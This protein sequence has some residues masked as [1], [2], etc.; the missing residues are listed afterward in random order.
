M[1]RLVGAPLLGIVGASGS[2]KS[3]AAA[4]RPA[5][6]RWTRASCREATAGRR[7]CCAPASTRRRAAQATAGADPRAGLLIA[8]DQFEET[9]T[10]CRDDAER[11]AFI[12]DARR[13][14]SAATAPVVLAVRADFYGRCAEYP[15]LAS[16]LG[17]NQ[18]LVGAMRRD[19]LRRAIE[20]PAERAGLEVEPELVDALLADT[21]G[22]AGGTAAAVDRAAGAVAAARRAPAASRLL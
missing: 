22:R 10:L 17:D 15:E 20:M 16:L 12:A 5:A 19:E 4:S 2:G 18:L 21:D 7:S 9:F 14:A 11:A 6:P 13:A 3:S 8:V 1:A